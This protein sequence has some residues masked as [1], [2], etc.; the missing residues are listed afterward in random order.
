M[1]PA[2]KVIVIFFAVVI[3][4]VVFSMAIEQSGFDYIEYIVSVVEAL[5][6]V[7][8]SGR[9]IGVL[10]GLAARELGQGWTIGSLISTSTSIAMIILAILMP[11]ILR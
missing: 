11:I 5:V 10:F 2:V 3:T 4:F 7:N 1:N 9:I 6:I 8:I